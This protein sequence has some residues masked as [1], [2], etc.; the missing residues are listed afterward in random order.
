MRVLVC[1]PE[2]MGVYGE[3]E[4]ERLLFEGAQAYRESEHKVHSFVTRLTDD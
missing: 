3:I 4:G 2:E 1:D